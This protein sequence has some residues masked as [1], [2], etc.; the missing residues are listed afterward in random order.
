MVLCPPKGR[1]L[2]QEEGILSYSS[3]LLKSTFLQWYVFHSYKQ[4]TE[5]EKYS[6]LFWRECS[7]RIENFQP[8]N[9]PDWVVA[10]IS[11]LFYNIH[12]SKG[13]LQF[14]IGKLR[15]KLNKIQKP[16]IVVSNPGLFSLSIRF[17]EWWWLIH[18]MLLR[19]K[20]IS[21]RYP[22]DPTSLS[23]ILFSCYR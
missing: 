7:S 12:N 16:S 18:S 14:I 20:S 13:F 23:S 9:R 10:I 8:D 4:E 6:R 1:K 15:K 17:P 22:L 5:E 19:I 3:M 21:K 2:I 11:R